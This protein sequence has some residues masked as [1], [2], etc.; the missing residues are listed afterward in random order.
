[1]SLLLTDPMKYLEMM[2]QFAKEEKVLQ[3]EALSSLRNASDSELLAGIKFIGAALSSIRISS[4]YTLKKFVMEQFLAEEGLA[5]KIS[6][7]ERGLDIPNPIIVQKYLN[8]LK[9]RVDPE[10]D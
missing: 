10:I 8:L 1:M 2:E 4:G 6:N 7:I 3:T 5:Y 9:D